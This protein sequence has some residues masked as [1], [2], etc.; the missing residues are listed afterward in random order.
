MLS[1]FVKVIQ[2]DKIQLDRNVAYFGDVSILQWASNHSCIT[3]CK[4][5]PGRM[6]PERVTCG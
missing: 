1:S 6:L 5:A 3:F 4:R 2:P